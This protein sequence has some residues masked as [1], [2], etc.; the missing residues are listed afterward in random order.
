MNVRILIKIFSFLKDVKK[1]A[2]N[3]DNF[4]VFEDNMHKV[5]IAL[6]CYVHLL[7]N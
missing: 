6:Q 1:V 7:D 2:A 3:D 5:A 4:F